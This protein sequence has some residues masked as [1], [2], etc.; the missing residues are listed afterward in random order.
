MAPKARCS[1]S[2]FESKGQMQ[3][4]L[5]IRTERF[6]TI[7]EERRKQMSEHVISRGALLKGVGVATLSAG[8]GGAPGAA[9]ACAWAR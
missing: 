2:L 7:F 8:M 1:T 4:E 6:P 3:D 5:L 9:G